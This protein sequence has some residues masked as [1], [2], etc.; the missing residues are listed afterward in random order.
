MNRRDVLKGSIGGIG[1]AAIAGA[2]TIFES[3]AFAGSINA[4]KIGETASKCIAVGLV[5]LAH[6]QQSLAQGSKEM[7]ACSA[8]VSDMLAACETLQKLAASNSPHLAAMA[9]VCGEIC[10]TCATKCEP[11]SKNMDVCKACMNACKSCADACL[12]A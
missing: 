9:K 12:H 6:C 10:K 4:E 7:A 8:S 11:H 3:A 5:C 1:M 2:S